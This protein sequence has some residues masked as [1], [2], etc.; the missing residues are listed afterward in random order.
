M[1]HYG[2]LNA[3][4]VLCTPKD[5]HFSPSNDVMSRWEEPLVFV[6]ATTERSAMRLLEISN[7]Q[8]NLSFLSLNKNGLFID[9]DGP[10][11]TYK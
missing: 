11:D 6:F 10:C 5:R 7:S 1:L 9:M 3:N 8:I 4:D 2:C